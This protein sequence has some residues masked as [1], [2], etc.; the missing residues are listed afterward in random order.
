MPLLAIY[1]DILPCSFPASTQTSFHSLSRH[2]PRHP[3]TPL[4]TPCNNFL[5][6]A[7]ALRA[8]R[9]L[10]VFE[11]FKALTVLTALKDFLGPRALEVYNTLYYIASTPGSPGALGG[12]RAEPRDASKD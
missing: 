6:L 9:I 7:Q 8:L 12:G 11:A 1:P 3:P 2:L 5:C 4:P 10:I